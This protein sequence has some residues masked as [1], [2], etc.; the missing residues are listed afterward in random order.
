MPIAIV[1][2]AGKTIIATLHDV[3]WNAG[4]VESG[5]ASHEHDYGVKGAR[6]VI[7]MQGSVA[8]ATEKS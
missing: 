1:D 4:K 5:L 3:L 2:E 7:V 6:S 8:S